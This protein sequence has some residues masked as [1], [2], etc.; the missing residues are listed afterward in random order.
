ML[1]MLTLVTRAKTLNNYLEDTSINDSGFHKLPRIFFF[2]PSLKCCSLHFL[3]FP[4]ANQ[5][6]ETLRTHLA[7]QTPETNFRVSS[8]SREVFPL[9]KSCFA[10]SDG[11]QAHLISK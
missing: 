3:C 1:H 9:I 10:E 6:D 5:V 8:S 2:S 11:S 7:P 4:V